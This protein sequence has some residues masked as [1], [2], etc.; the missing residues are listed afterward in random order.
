MI[1]KLLFLYHGRN[2]LPSSSPATAGPLTGVIFLVI[3]VAL[4]IGMWMYFTKKKKY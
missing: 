3:V 2:S 1:D 4:A